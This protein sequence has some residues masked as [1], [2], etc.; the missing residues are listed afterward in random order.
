MYSQASLP[1]YSVIDESWQMIEMKTLG[2]L[3]SQVTLAA[4][5]ANFT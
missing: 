3:I 4:A 5:A 1:F 2:L